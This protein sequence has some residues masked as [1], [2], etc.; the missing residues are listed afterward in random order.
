MRMQ[1][2]ENMGA[3]QSFAAAKRA[4]ASAAKFVAPLAFQ[5]LLMALGALTANASVLGAGGLFGLAVIFGAKNKHA[6]AITAGACLCYILTLP[7]Q[8]FTPFLG[9]A[10]AALFMRVLLWRKKRGFLLYGVAATGTAVFFILTIMRIHNAAGGASLYIAAVLA[11]VVVFALSIL[12]S[13]FYGINLLRLDVRTLSTEQGVVL[14]VALLILL[15]SL[16]ALAPWQLNLGVIA[17]VFCACAA[18]YR[19]GAAGAFLGGICALATVLPAAAPKEQAFLA[20]GVLAGT[21]LT[22]AFASFGRYAT[23]AAFMC[24]FMLCVA[25]EP[26]QR[27]MF[28]LLA[29]TGGLAVFMALPKHV[30]DLLP[31]KQFFESGEGKLAENVNSA[32]KALGDVAGAVAEV[33]ELLLKTRAPQV[34]V[35]EAVCER[36]CSKCKQNARCWIDSYGDVYEAFDHMQALAA[37]DGLEDAA[38]PQFLQANCSK[39]QA[40]KAQFGVFQQAAALQKE[41][42]VKHEQYRASL[43]GQFKAM[44]DT[45]YTIAQQNAQQGAANPRTATRVRR[46]LERCG[47]TVY[48]TTVN[49]GAQRTSVYIKTARFNPS[50]ED[51]EQLRGELS[52]LCDSELVLAQRKNYGGVT[53]LTF[54]EG[55]QL[56]AQ[57]GSFTLAGDGNQSA[58]A[59]RAFTD[60]RGVAH[61]VLCDGMGTGSRAAVDGNMAAVLI[62][63]LIKAGYEPQAAAELSN[64]ALQQKG[65]GEAASCVDILSCDLFTGAS[66]IYKAGAAPSLVVKNGR[67]ALL[68][69][70]SLPIGILN[71]VRGKHTSVTLC[72]GDTAVLVSDG[73]ADS[74]C[75]W[76]KELVSENTHLGAQQL[77][78]AIVAAAKQRREQNADDIT[79]AVLKL[80][81]NI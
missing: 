72:A 46:A 68:T 48:E 60:E 62:T 33:N 20:L 16:G 45:L 64:V 21:L 13:F 25:G 29:V 67:C 80:A 57:F 56:K 30:L 32:A 78:E 11:A 4:G 31:S 23:A 79:A 55:A 51:L 38:L 41:L 54:L 49:E 81:A 63:R 27:A 10:L 74:D 66:K 53:S 39:A 44:A 40:V 19:L 52:L 50:N 61:I 18:V 28:S 70:Q 58:D 1:K 15:S 17:A 26:V 2:S 24:G 77:A 43:L 12:L 35:A 65:D 42:A 76:L 34:S 59:V 7:T 73:A 14:C 37:A 22:C 71:D 69:S 8:Q 47:L 9:A 36:V 3:A 5:G 75:R 6:Y